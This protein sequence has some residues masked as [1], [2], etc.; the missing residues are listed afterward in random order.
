MPS[1]TLR[2]PVDG[3][4]AVIDRM[5]RLHQARRRR[6]RE[7]CRLAQQPQ[8]RWRRGLRRGSPAHGP[9][10]PAAQAAAAV[11]DQRRDH[12]PDQVARRDQIE[13]RA[14]GETRH[15]EGRRS[16]QPHRAIGP[17]AARKTAQRIGI[18]QQ[19]HRR[20]GGRGERQTRS[21]SRAPP[22]PAR[23]RHSRPPPP[24]LRCTITARSASR[25]SATRAAIGMAKIRTIIGTASTMPIM[26]ASRPL[27]AS[28]T[29]RNGT[30]T[31]SVR[32]RAA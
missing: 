7:E 24:P 3:R 10:A 16:P 28:Q 21:G 22:P 20:V 14:G 18:G 13:Q 9:A 11:S 30:C 1:K 23:A 17:A 19:H 12:Q 2:L 8:R 29:G 4:E 5:A 32:N 31:P 27:A 6:D 26:R 25:R 15:D